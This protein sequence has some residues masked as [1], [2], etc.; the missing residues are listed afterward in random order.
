[1]RAWVVCGVVNCNEVH[2]VMC[3]AVWDVMMWELC[4]MWVCG[5]W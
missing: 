5:V 2:V 3:N 1:M 4:D